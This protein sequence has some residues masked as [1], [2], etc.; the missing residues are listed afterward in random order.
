[1]PKK[2]QFS[3]EKF[4]N[5]SI[6]KSV[7][8]PTLNKKTNKVEQ[9]TV[10]L[11]TRNCKTKLSLTYQ[12]KERKAITNSYEACYDLTT[13]W[14]VKIDKKKGVIGSVELVSIKA[15][16]NNDEELL[17]NLNKELN[18][19][20]KEWYASNTPAYF[21]NKIQD[22]VAIK[23]QT[24]PGQI[25]DYN[26]KKLPSDKI[27]TISDNL[28]V[29]QIY[30]DPNKYMTSPRSMY[31]DEPTAYYTF[32]PE[33]F[34][35]TF[36]DD[37]K[38]GELSVKFYDGTLSGPL[39]LGEAEMK[40]REALASVNQTKEE[41]FSVIEN[42]IKKPNAENTRRF[43]SMFANNGVVE[44][45]YFSPKG[46]NRESR[47]FSTYVNRLK[48]GKVV[49]EQIG[50]PTVNVTTDPWT[51]T[52]V[53]TQKTSYGIYCDHTIKRVYLVKDE[54][55]LFKIVNVSVENDPSLC[56]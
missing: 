31:V 45:A 2:N 7:A 54:N 21:S 11:D 43:K 36:T 39:T 28:P 33:S 37:Y 3:I 27:V 17:R 15:S 35:I 25:T 16:P 9:Y 20:I 24:V 30:V 55:G 44:I 10:V 29:V 34:V 13:T 19:L 51:A 52:I 18:R 12:D 48:G 40:K 4:S 6:S 47:N 53:Y 5:N 42:F 23:C 1:M 22:D 14:V 49:I 32:R 8:K 38:Q 26:I 50:E 46:I 41:L 56:E